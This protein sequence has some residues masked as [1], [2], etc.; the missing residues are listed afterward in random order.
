MKLLLWILLFSFP[1]FVQAEDV[2]KEADIAYAKGN[3]EE[4]KSILKNAANTGNVKAQVNLGFMYEHGKGIPVEYDKALYWYRKAAK[5]SNANA[6]FNIG[7][8][9]EMERE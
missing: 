9:Y 5:K 1:F 3:Y 7:Y 6:Q 8:M 4:A 2:L